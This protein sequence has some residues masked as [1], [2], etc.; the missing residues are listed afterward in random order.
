MDNNDIRPHGKWEFDSEH[1]EFGNPYGTYKCSRCGGHS[2]DK[3][4]Y[5]FW[6]GADMRGKEK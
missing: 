2:S 1:T 4:P 3:Y 6:C 5:C